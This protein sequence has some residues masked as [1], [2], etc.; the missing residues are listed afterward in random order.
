[1]NVMVMERVI[2]LNMKRKDH[3][4]TYDEEWKDILRGGET[5]RMAEEHVKRRS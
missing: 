5:L 3:E 4:Q 2:A 1:M